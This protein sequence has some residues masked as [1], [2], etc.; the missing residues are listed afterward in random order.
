MYFGT[1]EIYM[2]NNTTRDC[3]REKELKGH[4]FASITNIFPLQ[5]SWEYFAAIF[6]KGNK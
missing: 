5:K 6:A 2:K 3:L 1:T 4:K